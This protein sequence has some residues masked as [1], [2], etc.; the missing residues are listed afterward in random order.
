[1][2][3][4]KIQGRKLIDRLKRHPHTYAQML[5]YGIS[6]SPWKRVPE[7]LGVDEQLLKVENRQGLITWR[8][9]K[10]CR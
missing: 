10:V 8:V 1:M 7:C 5:Q 6:N 9:V 3:K 2:S 4:C